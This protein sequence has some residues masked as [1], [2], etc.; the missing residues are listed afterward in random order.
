MKTAHARYRSPIR[1]LCAWAVALVLVLLA[2]FFWILQSRLR[3]IVRVGDIVE[4]AT[5]KHYAAATRAMGLEPR[6]SMLSYLD[7][8]ARGN[9]RGTT[10]V[11]LAGLDA[12]VV[13]R[14]GLRVEGAT[15]RIV[16]MVYYESAAPALYVQWQGDASLL[17]SSPKVSI[18]RTRVQ[19]YSVPLAWF[20]GTFAHNGMLD[21][22]SRARLPSED[23][24]IEVIPA[25][26]PEGQGLKAYF[27]AF[28]PTPAYQ[29]HVFE[30][31]VWKG[32]VAIYSRQ[33]PD[34][35]RVRIFCSDGVC[36]VFSFGARD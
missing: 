36:R 19:L 35:P 5:R 18:G 8:A 11:Y 14:D 26:E 33:K 4:N 30:S 32:S 25:E 22:L 17:Y 27:A 12:S 31:G 21:D 23:G 20:R 16:E 3:E 9:G 34:R 1:N 7:A 28:V 13:E 2:T 29:I 10:E 15:A 24:W 6:K